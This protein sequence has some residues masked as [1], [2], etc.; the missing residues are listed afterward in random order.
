MQKLIEPVTRAT[1]QPGDIFIGNDPYVGQRP[2]STGHLHHAAHLPRRAPV[3]LG[4]PSPTMPTSAGWSPGSNSIGAT[5]ILSGGAAPAVPASW[6]RRGVATPCCWTIIAANVRVPGQVLGDLRAQMAACAAGEQG[7]RELVVRV[8]RRDHRQPTGD[9]LQDYAEKLAGVTFGEIPDGAYEFKDFIDGLR[10][11]PRAHRAAV[12]LTVAGARITADWAGTSPQVKGGIN[13]PLSFLKSNVYAALRSI[14][15]VD[16]PN[17]H[18]YARL[19]DVV[20]PAQG[21]LVNCVRSAPCGARGVT[22]YR[23]VDCIF[24]ALAAGSA[25][26]GGGGRGGR[27]QPAELRRLRRRQGLRLF[28]MRHGHLGR[29]PRATTARRGARAWPPTS[30]TCRS[31]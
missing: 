13:A 31:R 12:K 5:E 30:P 24:V 7:L 19:I 20:A 18:G 8:R 26:Q 22:G 15:S 4:L 28:R 6:S 11:A 3:R 25:G 16:V 9:A 23:I 2:A 17:C 27:V 14:M 29:A 10:R 1:S 21:T